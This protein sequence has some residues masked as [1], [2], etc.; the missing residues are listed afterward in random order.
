MEPR[1]NDLWFDLTT[2]LVWR[3]GVTGIVRAELEIGKHL[4]AHD[5]R[6][7]FCA[8]RDTDF[9]EVPRAKLDWLLS[10]TNVIDAYLAERETLRREWP[11]TTEKQSDLQTILD[12]LNDFSPR[13][14]D[15]LRHAVVF[16]VSLLPA[17]AAQHVLRVPPV[18]SGSFRRAARPPVPPL[19]PCR[20][21]TRTPRRC[22][23]PSDPRFTR[24]T[25]SSA[26]AGWTPARSPTSP[27]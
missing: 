16:L 6:V 13:R 5:R 23:G 17:A 9:V 22:P 19:H 27:P 2:S 8:L 18:R 12:E 1:R 14:I 26:S 7:R 21:K 20:R 3:G 24:R 25:R 15:R 11:S 4:A 10:A